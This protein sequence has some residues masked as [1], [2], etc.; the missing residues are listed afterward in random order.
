MRTFLRKYLLGFIAVAGCM[1]CANFN[2][3]D[4]DLQAILLNTKGKRHV[5]ASLDR[6]HINTLKA[7]SVKKTKKT[8]E[9]GVEPE[10]ISVSHVSQK[11]EVQRYLKLYTGKRRNDVEKPLVKRAEHLPIITAVLDYYNLP[12]ELS[13]LAFVESKFDSAATSPMGAKGIWQLMRPT[14]EGLGLNC[15]FWN[16]ER[17]DVLRSS[18]AAA[19]YIKEL[20][21]RFGD[22]LLVVAAY[23]AG[24]TRVENAQIRSGKNRDFFTLAKKG[25]LPKETV[26]HVSKFIA[27]TMITNRPDLYGF[28][29]LAGNALT[30]AVGDLPL[31]D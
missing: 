6:S 10:K 5:R 25:L 11:A 30:S 26:H 4:Q 16:D 14:A 8:V 24:P 28:D 3:V 20:K 31:V 19:R 27:L 15:R 7:P 29:S 1:S 9:R 13:N 23:N 12:A 17:K 21:S 18:I 22:W 2:I